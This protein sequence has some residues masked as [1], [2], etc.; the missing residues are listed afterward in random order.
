MPKQ[1]QHSNDAHDSDKSKGPNR[2]D[3]SVT[4]VTGSPKKEER[5]TEQA[6]QG[7]DPGVQPQAAKNEW[8]EDTHERPKVDGERLRARRG[9]VSVSGRAHGSGSDSNAGSGSRGY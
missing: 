7:K 9:D 6:R 8:N 2:P 4:I 1:G 3:K 5:Y